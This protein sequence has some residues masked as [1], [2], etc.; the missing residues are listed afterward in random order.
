[1]I[2]EIC[3]FLYMLTNERPEENFDWKNSIKE[4]RFFYIKEDRKKF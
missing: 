4:R 3:L 1:M 2:Y